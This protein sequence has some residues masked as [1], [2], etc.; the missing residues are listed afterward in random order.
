MKNSVDEA[1]D[2]DD[3]LKASNE[4]IKLKLELE[5]GMQLQDISALSPEM[6]NQWLNQIYNF[7]KQHRDAPRIKLYDFIDRPTFLKLDSM[8]GGQV[9]KELKRLLFLLEEKDIALDCCCKYAD[10]I[11]YQFLTEE[12]FEHEMDSFSMAGMM[13]HFIYEE[14]HPNHDFDLRRYAKYFIDNIFNE[15][16]N[17]QWSEHSLAESICFCGKEHTRASISLIIMTFQEAHTNLKVERSN[18][19]NVTFDLNSNTGVVEVLLAYKAFT[20]QGAPRKMKGMSRIYF[21][22]SYDWWNICGFKFP[23]F[24]D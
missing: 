22:R 3:D 21:S 23:G 20:A 4:L 24:G 10:S 8:K 19:K 6:E 7:E 14:F 5:H 13:H 2:P 11:I 9:K 1:M 15:K 16:W 12:L 17:E 18:I